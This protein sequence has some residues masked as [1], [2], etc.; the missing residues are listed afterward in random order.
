[1]H[2][3]MGRTYLTLCMGCWR[4]IEW[5]DDELGPCLSFVCRVHPH[6]TLLGPKENSESIA[7]RHN[8]F[9]EQALQMMWTLFPQV[10]IQRHVH[11]DGVY[12]GEQPTVK[13]PTFDFV[14]PEYRL[15]IDFE[16]DD[17]TV[18]LDVG[19]NVT[20]IPLITRMAFDQIKDIATRDNNWRH[21]RLPRNLPMARD[22]LLQKINEFYVLDRGGDAQ[23]L[24]PKL[25]GDAGWD[26]I[27]DADTICPPQQGTDISSELFLEIPNH[28]YALVQARSSTSKKRLLVLPGVIDPS[29]RGRL[30][31]MAY[32]LTNESITVHKGDRIAQLLFFPRVPHL[33]MILVDSL[34]S[35]ERGSR[36]FG[37]TG[38]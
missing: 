21:I 2:H 12:L 33:K 11:L 32:N 16:S 37:S 3:L 19:R 25:Q 23:I 27:S 13:H 6:K 4:V 34:R 9:T 29:Y 17:Q 14:I 35:S 26:I 30:Y 7:I 8:K 22:I 15:A 10:E 24:P 38:Q 18:P 31:V 1:M 28:L 5:C 20:S 36:G